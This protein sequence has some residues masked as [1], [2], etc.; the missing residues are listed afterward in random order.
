MCLG[1]L[2]NRFRTLSQGISLHY[3][4]DAARMIMSCVILQNLCIESGDDGEQYLEPDLD[5]EYAA[6]EEEIENPSGIQ[7]KNALIKYLRE[8]H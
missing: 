8:F 2:K 7:A 3:E 6:N 4:D 1:I 5:V